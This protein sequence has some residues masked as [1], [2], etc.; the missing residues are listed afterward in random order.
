MAEM[1]YI[2]MG[3]IIP[4]YQ[5]VAVFFQKCNTASVTALKK[6]VSRMIQP[7]TCATI[8]VEVF[9]H[10]SWIQLEI[11]HIPQKFAIICSN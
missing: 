2:N 6:V 7:V 11:A 3:L 9:E 1:C 5:Q 4:I 8:T 10:A